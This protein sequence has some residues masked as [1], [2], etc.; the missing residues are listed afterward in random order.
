MRKKI[1]VAVMMF[2]LVIVSSANAFY[3][4]DT[5]IGVG[6]SSYTLEKKCGAPISKTTIGTTSEAEGYNK[7]IIEKWIYEKDGYRMIITVTG[8]TVT[9]IKEEKMM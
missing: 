3:C 4:G 8:D 6:T 5:P 1:I 2:S 7:L 9:Y